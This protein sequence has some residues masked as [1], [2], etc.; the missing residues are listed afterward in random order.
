MD[1]ICGEL[2][3]KALGMRL[4]TWDFYKN[5]EPRVKSRELRGENQEGESS[6]V[7]RNFKQYQKAAMLKAL[8]H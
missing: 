4:E 5:Q 8:D 7:I 2:R 1:G 6:L 3:A